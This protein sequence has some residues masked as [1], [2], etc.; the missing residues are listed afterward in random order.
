MTLQEHRGT[1]PEPGPP[2]APH[3]MHHVDAV[4]QLLALQ[5]GVQ[6]VEEVAQVRLAVAVR[7]DDGG[8]GS[9]L[10]GLGLVAPTGLHRRV[11]GLDLLQG[12]HTAEGHRQRADC[13]GREGGGG[14]Q[15]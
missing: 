14:T 1:H 11:L 5:E 12:G 3:L 7:D 4:V 15:R 9:W 6:V 13:G 8:A 2:G 10:T